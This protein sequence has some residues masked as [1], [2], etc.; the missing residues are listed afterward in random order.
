MVL[1]SFLEFPI[2]GSIDLHGSS[3]AFEFVGC[4]NGQETGGFGRMIEIG[5]K[6]AEY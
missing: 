5:F 3:V 2:F 4:H 6:F 1:V